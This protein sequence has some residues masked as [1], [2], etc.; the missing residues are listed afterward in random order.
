MRFICSRSI[1]DRLVLAAVAVLGFLSPLP[2]QP[3]YKL[4]VKDHLKPLALLS[5][6]GGKLSRSAVKDDPG[7][8]LQ[9]HFKK[10]GKSLAVVE[11]R[12]NPVLPISQKQVGTYSVVLELFYPAYK[13]GTLQK[14]EFKPISP[15]L[16]FRIEAGAKPTEPVRIVFIEPP[17]PAPLAA[18]APVLAIQCGKGAGKQQ[19]ERLTQGY[20]YKLL[21]GAPFDGWLKTAGK[22][23]CW[24]DAKM[25]R[26]EVTVPSGTAGTLRLLFVDG[27]NLQ[28][29]QR[30]SVQGKARGEFKAFAGPGKKLEVVLTAADTKPGKIEVALENLNAAANAVVSTVKF[31]PALPKG[32]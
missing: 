4:V 11:A 10:D 32:K 24:Y 14:G 8:R 31:V 13:G 7:F 19:D 25:V 1:P 26:F 29:K 23:H 16:G 9:Y 30:A 5:L 3:S 28:R 18:G 2:A 20:G 22:T 17:K 21:Q 6:Q 15:P 27:D 12:S